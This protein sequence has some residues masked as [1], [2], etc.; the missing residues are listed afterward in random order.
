MNSRCSILPNLNSYFDFIQAYQR[1]RKKIEEIRKSPS[2]LKSR[3]KTDV[4]K[5][6]GEEEWKDGK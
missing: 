5:V 2:L 6:V 3:V 4:S 1:H